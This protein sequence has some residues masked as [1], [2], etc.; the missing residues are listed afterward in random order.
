MYGRIFESRK[1]QFLYYLL[2]IGMIFISSTYMIYTQH[3]SLPGTFEFQNYS[4]IIRDIPIMILAGLWGL[5]PAMVSF[6]IVLADSLCIDVT[7]AYSVSVYLIASLL[8]YYFSQQ[9]WYR[10]KSLTALSVVISVGALGG[11]WNIVEALA[12]QQGILSI[13]T[14][15]FIYY[16]ICITPE[17][18]FTALFFWLFFNFAP[19]PLRRGFYLG[20]V[21]EKEDVAEEFRLYQQQLNSRLSQTLT[22]MIVVEAVLLGVCAAIFAAQLI[23]SMADNMIGTG[24]EAGETAE[25]Y[26]WGAISSS[27]EQSETETSSETTT[28]TNTENT[29]EL[30]QNTS[31]PVS[32]DAH[33]L[34]NNAG[35]AFI[36]KM[37]ILIINVAVPLIVLAN[38]FVQNRV[39]RPIIAMSAT[40]KNF[41][42]S[43]REE[44][45]DKLR[46]LSKMNIKGKD[47]IAV[48]Y[49]NMAE[50]AYQ[51]NSFV[52]QTLR[53]QKLE[54]DL[55]VAKRASENK[56]AFLNNV[57]HEIRTPINA[58][59][60]MD[61]MILRE[62][63]EEH[64]L[65]YAKDIK[66]SGKTL[67]S[68]VNDILDSSKLEAG[69]MEILPVEYDVSSLVNDIVN[70]IAF[71]AKDKH[72]EFNVHVDGK[73]PHLLYGD[74]IRIK[75]VMVNILTNAVKYTEKGS[76]DF[77][78]GYKKEDEEHITLTC[79]VQDTGIGIKEEDMEKL[80]SR[81]ERIDE[82]KNRTIEGT[83]LGMNIVKQL[84]TLM[85]SELAVESQY[86]KG[87][88]FSFGLKQKV[89]NWDEI[90]S[91]E[92]SYQHTEGTEGYRESFQAPDARILVTDDTKMNLTVIQALLKK[93]KVQVDTAE[94]GFETLYKVREKKYDVIFLDHRMPEMDGI[95]TL[96]RLRQLEGN[97][98][99]DTPV[100]S[101][102]ANAVS[103]AR[104]TYL[105]AGFVDYLSKPIDSVKLEHMLMEYLPKEKVIVADEDFGEADN[106]NNASETIEETGETPEPEGERIISEISK[107]KLLNL[108]EAYK[109][110]GGKGTFLEVLKDY[111]SVAEKKADDIEHCWQ[112]LDYDTYTVLVHALKS[113]SRLIGEEA[114]SDE[115]RELEELGNKALAGDEDAKIVINEK[116][117]K[118]LSHYRKL[119]DDLSL[120]L[121]WDDLTESE[122][123][124]IDAYGLKD[125]L[126]TIKEFAVA[127]DFDSADSVM[128][129]LDNYRIPEQYRKGLSA[130]KD[131]LKAVDRQLLIEK[132]EEMGL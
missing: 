108:Q 76:V 57:S 66:N 117:P 90:G 19:S 41:A 31:E 102:T 25:V 91:Y 38:A 10:K 114:L 56:S 14:D 118:V 52:D 85:D 1:K 112:V 49:D 5:V 17:M 111:A 15:M 128:K 26:D 3:Y 75:Q 4:F 71:R 68:L 78:L 58:V 16:M 122:K 88:T 50:M 36:L 54:E 116:T 84:L 60:G 110:C 48:L 27:E 18:L 59:L 79:K 70:M 46:E 100:I 109:N 89:V 104:E 121:Q 99:E 132:I 28:E 81:F 6:S 22:S 65:E 127:Y 29:Q 73:I 32:E 20:L 9:G 92:E 43:S 37:I 7:A 87:S 47:E 34:L 77:W 126:E 30:T 42:T 96:Q 62:S 80:F 74:E 119:K 53:E 105:S 115:A 83:G 86:Q 103:G 45:E 2:M 82:G 120:L 98:N 124:E 12:T 39:A 23:P 64:I 61:E 51:V 33:F 35:V 107:S 69:K 130:V 125:G 44:Q 40:I 55:R 67:L 93:T 129:M 131:A 24:M 21:Y 101:L 72:L 123:E 106:E 8:F 97:L 113:S 13:S 94:S 63:N 11:I 95:E